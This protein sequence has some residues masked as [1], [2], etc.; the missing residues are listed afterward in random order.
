MEVTIRFYWVGG[1]ATLPFDA[2][3]EV[4]HQPLQVR[5]SVLREHVPALVE[6]FEQGR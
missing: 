5:L 4:D 3:T 2:L 1:E 6:Q